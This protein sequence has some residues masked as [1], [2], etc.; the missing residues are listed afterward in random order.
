[1]GKTIEELF[2]TKKL[3]AFL[4]DKLYNG[5]NNITVNNKTPFDDKIWVV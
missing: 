1:M 4:L 3:L 2:K 5:E